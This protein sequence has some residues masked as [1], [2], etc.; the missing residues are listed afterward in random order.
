[1]S[2]MN[3]NRQYLSEDTSYAFYPKNALELFE[4]EKNRGYI[5]TSCT[6][7]DNMLGGGVE[8]GKITEFCGDENVDKAQI[9]FENQ[10]RHN[11]VTN[12]I[13]K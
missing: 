3:H 4:E 2:I 7:I 11:F 5:V 6:D 12:I 8:T 10:D 9:R 13:I 1:M